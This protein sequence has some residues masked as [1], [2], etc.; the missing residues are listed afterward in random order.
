MRS[1]IASA[2]V[3]SPITCGQ[4]STGIWRTQFAC[5]YWKRWLLQRDNQD[6]SH[7]FG[8]GSGGRQLQSSY[9]LL[10]L[11]AAGMIFFAPSRPSWHGM[12][13]DTAAI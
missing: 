4:R 12:G 5:D 9:A 3:D 13:D 7:E 1:R 10:A 11:T 8:G 2:I 6:E